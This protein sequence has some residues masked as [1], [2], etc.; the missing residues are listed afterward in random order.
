MSFLPGMFPG[1]APAVAK[2]FSLAF[3][4]Q[5]LTSASGSS[6][7]QTL[8]FGAVPGA[9]QTRYIVATVCSLIE[10]ANTVTIGG[11]AATIVANSTDHRGSS[12]IAIAAVPTGT[13]GTVAITFSTSR[14][15]AAISTYR[16]MNPSSAT[17]TAT[18]T[19]AHDGASVTLTDT[20]SLNVSA[21][22]GV[23]ACDACR[24]RSGADT[25]TWVGL[26]DDGQLS[27]PGDGNN[28][29]ASSA[30][31]TSVSGASPLTI[32]ADID[33]TINGGIGGACATWSPL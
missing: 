19:D 8:S 32:T 29:R 26:T 17:P 23:V 15:Q 24:N 2:P 33:V 30:H 1:V 10:A 4:D 7:S 18:A 5:Q 12:V 31:T 16:L 14:T 27:L 21:G 6:Q 13:S 11:V 3:L 22:G 28:D 9:G 20:L 25:Y